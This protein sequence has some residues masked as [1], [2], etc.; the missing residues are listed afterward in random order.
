MSAASI[1]VDARTEEKEVAVSLQTYI[2]QD[3][4]RALA[5]GHALPDRTSGAALFADISGFTALTEGLRDALGSRQGA[6]ELTRHLGI[7]YSALIAEVEKHDGSVISF[8]GDAV[9][10]WFDGADAPS[11]AVTCAFDLQ[12]AMQAFASIALPQGA[13]AAL[14][15]KV[16]VAAGE[17]RRFVVGDPEI[18][19]IDALAGATVSRT[20]TGEHLSGKGEILVDEA[21]TK[22]LGQSLDV[23][24][25]RTAESGERFAV[26]HGLSRRAE[27]AHRPDLRPLDH[28]QLRPWIDKTVYERES[29][30]QGSFLT[31]FR[32]GAVLFVNFAGMDYDAGDAQARLDAFVRQLQQTAA[33]YGGTLLQ[34]NIGDKGSYAFVNFGALSA[35]EDDPRRAV[36]T[37]L[38]FRQSTDLQLRM[39]IAQGVMRVGA[40][41]GVTRR[42]YGA[43]GD[44][45]NLA[46]RLMT[47]AEAGEILV[48]GPVHKSV[49][50]LFSA[51]PRPPLP[52]KGKAEPLPVFV[53]TGERKV[54]AIRLQEPT[55]ALPMVG[56]VHELERVNARL[57][58]A[59]QGKGQVI[60][61]VAEA[62]M[63]KSR[64]VAEIIRSARRKGFVGYGGAC[65]SHSIHTP[66]QAWKSVWQAFFEIDPEHPLRKQMRLLEGEIEDRAPTRVDAMPLLNVVVDLQIPDNEFTQPL[67][68]KTRQSALHALLEECLK[69][70]SQDEPILIVIEDL[71]WADALSL[72]LLEQLAKALVGHAVC[73]VLAYRPSQAGQASRLETLPQFTR[74]EL[75]ELTRGEAEQAIRAKLAQLYPA[76][77]G[78][79]PEGLVEALMARAQ[80]NPFYME[81]LLNYVRDRGLD[82][83]DLA[84]IELPDN[85][86]ALILSRIDELNEEE[87]VTLRVASV[88]GRLFR[89]DWLT[90]YYPELGA[91]RSVRASLDGLSNLDITPLDSPEPEWRYLFKHIVTHEVTYESLAYATRARL[92]EQLAKYLEGTDAA[93]EVIAFHYGRT[94]NT[95]KKIEYLRKSG[96]AAQRSFA[97][98]SALDYFSKLLALLTDDQEK[99]RVHLMRGQVLELMGRYNEAG[100]DYRAAL[101][102]AR[103]DL[104]SKASA[105]FALGKLDRLR[106]EYAKALDWLAQA[107][108]ARTQSKDP[109]GVA[110]TLIE[111]GMIL[112][113]TAEFDQA[114]AT[115]EQALALSRQAA[116]KAGEALALNSLGNL[117]WVQGEFDAARAHYEASMALRR[118]IGEKS[119]IAAS[120]SNLGA[121][122]LV[123]DDYASARPLLEESLSIRRGIGDKWGIA[124]SLTNL[125]VMAMWQGRY[126]EARAAY[127]ESLALRREMG[128]K[129]GTA[130]SLFNL[131]NVALAQGAF[132]ESLKLNEECLGLYREMGDKTGNA[133]ALCYIGIASLA[134]GDYDTARASLDQSLSVRQDIDDKAGKAYS[135]L[136]L[137]LLGL[138]QGTPDARKRILDALRL[139]SG[140]VGLETS[141]LIGAAGLALHE[142]DPSLAARL[143]GAVHA[144][145]TP[146]QLAVEPAVNFF[147]ARTLAKAK[148]ALGEAGFQSAWDEGCAWPLAEAIR[149]TLA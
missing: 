23:K 69:A 46:A 77:G 34:L 116:D 20:S 33:R 32:P 148:D 24:E 2:P 72:D 43:L 122:A 29:S 125:G 107:H 135:L 13:T 47:T 5:S 50:G 89:A 137:G 42:T 118:E 54:R 19:Y 134:A 87:K 96:E 83:S 61:V 117:A 88:I 68:P 131:G 101:S 48:S 8:A 31:E 52:M 95:P 129:V 67:E 103:G 3:R 139:A 60:A 56:R 79:L 36:K 63:G 126:G 147:H 91:F 16:C 92:H 37:A 59:A 66:Y 145:L 98:D 78:V 100:E 7:V 39:G 133:S 108:A 53:I 44:E 76:R 62:G 90:G 10:C 143:L 40:Y 27:V 112:T 55:Y 123:R 104:V 111:Q 64:L 45:V 102:S 21:T 9:T 84:H 110:Q 26:A 136:G 130:L 81:E 113:R 22:S 144:A 97:N 6:E 38:D 142:G 141:C 86:H 41:G 74:V 75:H 4:L 94:D 51:E 57:D 14:S 121:V 105:Q 106:G 140:K 30:G 18:S 82:P 119:S 114:H 115:L 11:R 49:E 109:A 138:A 127:E 1:H 128:D 146:L 93:V 71:H 149:R 70:A 80:G 132:V 17:A 15:L 25:W 85:L 73:F 28:D 12:A 99:F 65:Q 35:H 120:L 58:L 124:T